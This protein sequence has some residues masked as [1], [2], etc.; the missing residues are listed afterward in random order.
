MKQI[1]LVVGARPNFVKAG[2]LYNELKKEP[3]FKVEIVHT[4]QHYDIN[5]SDIFFKQLDL[6]TPDINLNVGSGPH[7][8]QTGEMLARLEE[9]FMKRKPDLVIVFGDTN[10]TLAGALAA[11]KL[12]IR[13]GHVEAGVR[14]YDMSMPEE[15]N[16]ILVDRISDLLFIP[17]EFAR[18]NL[19]E[20]G[21]STSRMFVVGNIL[22][23]TIT[24]H[25]SK[26]SAMEK[27]LLNQFSLKSGEYAVITVHRA[28]NVDDIEKLKNI[29]KIMEEV[30]RRMVLVFPVHPRTRSRL[31][32][33][34]FNPPENLKFIDPLGYLEFIALLK[35][36]ALVL[37]D[38][39]GVQTESSFLCVPCLTLREN[40]EWVIT[41]NKGTNV[42]VGYNLQ[43]IDEEI[44]KILEMRRVYGSY[45][46]GSRIKLW[47][48][49][50]SERIVAVIKETFEGDII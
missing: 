8:K 13:V 36:S 11:A 34:G 6:P 3:D 23:D 24:Q 37:T 46:A 26:I 31:N 22:M 35:N 16:R 27:E 9:L 41:L 1:T 19:S 50:T 43:K 18:L 42:L 25:M 2:P 7:G 48:G 12:G 47:D 28:G 30:S 21:V 15:I 40:T 38:S 10:S 32:E 5:M 49:R 14:S 39:G 17:D 4:G 44:T 20:E 29:I 33:L 45:V